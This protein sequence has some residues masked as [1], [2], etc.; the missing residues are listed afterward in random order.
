MAHRCFTGKKGQVDVLRLVCDF[1]MIVAKLL[2]ERFRAAIDF[3]HTCIS[4]FFLHGHHSGHLGVN[5]LLYNGHARP[6]RL[7]IEVF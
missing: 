5:F 3:S 7:E 4:H 2:F 1:E 6:H